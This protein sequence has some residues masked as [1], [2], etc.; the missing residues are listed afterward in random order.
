M[1]GTM[2]RIVLVACRLKKSSVSFSSGFTST[3]NSGSSRTRAACPAA[4]SG[5][6]GQESTPPALL[7]KRAD[8]L[9]PFRAHRMRRDGLALENHLRLEGAEGLRDEPLGGAVGAAR[10]AR[11]L[12]GE[13]ERARGQLLIVHDLVHQ[14]P[15]ERL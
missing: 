14:S 13:L 1:S 7:E 8:P 15:G 9:H 3:L 10:S 4:P 11:E 6:A 5:T 2:R 12:L